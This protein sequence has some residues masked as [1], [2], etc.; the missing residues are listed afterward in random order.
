MSNDLATLVVKMEAQTAK[1]DEAL[2][3]AQRRATSWEKSA[4]KSVFNVKA[5]FS[6]L[7][8]GAVIN[9]M[10]QATAKQEAAMTQLEQAFRTTGETSDLSAEKLA[11]YSAELQ[12]VTTFGDEEFMLAAAQLRS[13]T[14]VVEDEFK[15]T[16]E[17]SADLSAR[18]GVDLKSS[19]LQLGKALNDP[20]KNLSALSRAG[21]QFSEGQKDVIK[22]LV[23]SG[24][25]QEAQKVILA[26]LETQFGGSA[27]AARDDFGGALKALRNTTGDLM[28]ADSESLPA[29]V[30]S[31]NDLND[32]FSDPTFVKNI[33]A[34][35][36]AMIKGMGLAAKAISTTVGMASYLGEEIAARVGGAAL[37]DI[38]RL[39]QQLE[40]SQAKLEAF[41]VTAANGIN[42]N[43]PVWKQRVA[44]AEADVKKMEEQLRKGLE[45]RK[46]KEDM[47]APPEPKSQLLPGAAN[48]AGGA[49]PVI[50]G[51][52]PAE[53][54]KS[55]F[56]KA[57][58]DQDERFIG[59]QD[60]ISAD[61]KQL[62]EQQEQHKKAMKV[63][64]DQE[65]KYTKDLEAQE[66]ARADIR[67]AGFDAAEGVFGGMAALMKD[68]SKA[69]RALLAAEKAVGV[70]RA[71]VAMN[72]AMAKANSEG[73]IWEKAGHI[74]VAAM[75]GT[76]ALA[77]IKSVN[78]AGAA[79][80][81]LDNVPSEATYLLDKG[82]RVL[83]P[84]QNSDL[85]E[86]LANQDAA[87]E[88]MEVTVN[89]NIQA[90]DRQSFQSS[91]LQEE[92]IVE[93]I[94]ARAFNRRGVT[95]AIG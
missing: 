18:F 88:A 23:E 64:T 8:I 69:Q 37:D 7:A 78:V 94:L 33:H 38:V 35:T 4:K 16:L 36:N 34:V 29:V 71:V 50:P 63:L 73:T 62:E 68:G 60:S 89:F 28:E 55:R 93:G 87:N 54:E 59:L 1:Y 41:R 75:H 30:D 17:L 61:D 49:S 2:K 65:D 45:L 9:K 51:I 14:G 10:S 52:D 20:I 80:G 66:K 85:T 3:K 15:R 72:V 47:L 44:D 12:K 70:A 58:G 32:T 6:G 84:N 83:S 76:R 27:R 39:E 19:V 43:D 95:T 56:E 40:R 21:I 67:S 11:A 13:F 81:G 24:R 26:E 74:A 48:D 53:E 5:A 86:Y 42:K 31:I 57:F 25:L 79:H 82:E 77:G 91:L 90:I 92:Q 22:T 46:M